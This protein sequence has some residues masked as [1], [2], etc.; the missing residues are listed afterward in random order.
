MAY[1]HTD[2]FTNSFT[3]LPFCCGDS[4]QGN[5]NHWKGF[6]PYLREHHDAPILKLY[7]YGVKTKIQRSNVIF[8]G[9]F[10]SLF[11]LP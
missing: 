6:Q 3:F 10:K 2:K 8:A 11:L 1:K 5:P 7:N 9:K 4:P